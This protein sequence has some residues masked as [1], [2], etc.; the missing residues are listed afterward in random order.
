[1]DEIIRKKWIERRIFWLRGLRVMVST[2]LAELY[3]VEPRVLVQAVK[4]NSERFPADFMF[5]LN[6]QEF[7]NLKSQIVISSWGGIRTPPHAFTELGVAMLSTV[8]NSNQAIQVNIEIMRT[9]V[10]LRKHLASPKELSIRL[11]KLEN[12]YDIQFKVVFDAI[13]EIINPSEPRRRKIGFHADE[14]E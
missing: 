13:R 4:R 2:D 14:K 7:T 12:K 9:F 11:D 1:M 6:N 8:L 10:E 3:G 5:Q